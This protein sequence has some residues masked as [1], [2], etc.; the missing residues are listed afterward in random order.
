MKKM[1]SRSSVFQLCIALGFVSAIG[2]CGGTYESTVSGIVTLDGTPL[3]RGRVTFY[4]TTSGP[5]CIGRI[6]EQGHY[7]LSTG[8][9]VGLPPGE[10]AVTV[11]ANEPPKQSKSDR[12]GP[13]PAGKLI[14]PPWYKTKQQSGLQELV[15]P[16]SNEIELAL[17]S[18]P[19]GNWAAPRNK[20]SR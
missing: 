7:E 16:G 2:G 20:K 3:N 9:E 6:D 8:R 19:P 10:Y 1:T 13:P 11:V 4:P 5:P 15:E 14:T 18:E 12:G 17:T